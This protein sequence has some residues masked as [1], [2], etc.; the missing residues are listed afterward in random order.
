MDVPLLNQS[1]KNAIAQ[2]QFIPAKQNGEPI[3]TWIRIPIYFRIRR[4]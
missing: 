2:T 4:Y 1:A 3:T